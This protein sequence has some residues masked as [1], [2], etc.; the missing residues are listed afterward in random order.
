MIISENA[1][2]TPVLVISP[3]EHYLSALVDLL[4][5]QDLFSATGWH[6]TPGGPSQIIPGPGYPIVVVDG[7]VFESIRESRRAWPDAAII[8]SLDY[9]EDWD[10]FM[11]L[12]ADVCV[13]K[14]RGLPA[15]MEAISRMAGDSTTPPACS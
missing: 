14:D 1:F 12:G 10:L 4:G 15:I 6:P 3:D 13:L 11:S 5:A 7:S 2:T 8:C 9:I